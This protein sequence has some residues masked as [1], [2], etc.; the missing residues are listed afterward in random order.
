MSVLQ[1]KSTIKGQQL[2]S[3][4]KETFWLSPTRDIVYNFIPFC[5]KAFAY[6]ENHKNPVVVDYYARGGTEEEMAAFAKA[7]VA[8]VKETKL[9]KEGDKVQ[10]AVTRS[11]I[12]DF[13]PRVHGLFGYAYTMVTISHYYNSL[14]TSQNGEIDTEAF[15]KVEY[16]EY[17]IK[18]S[19]KSW[20]GIKAWF[21][22]KFAK[23]APSSPTPS[24]PASTESPQPES[25]SKTS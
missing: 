14:S 17:S 9:Y 13:P 4:D 18:P 10:Q 23:E 24:L 19:W 6:M 15:F 1:F 7:M 22:Q 20:K 2:Q 16:L 12:L 11:G 21:K 25:D 3:V 8:F 5:H